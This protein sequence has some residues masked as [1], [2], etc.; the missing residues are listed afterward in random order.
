MVLDRQRSGH[1]EPVGAVAVQRH[2]DGA[3]AAVAVAR[4]FQWHTRRRIDH[5]ALARGGV[6]AGE[7]ER[8]QR[9]RTEIILRAERKKVGQGKSV[10]VRV[11]IDGRGNNK[12]KKK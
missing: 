1:V 6:P 8:T 12:K 10:S 3:E 11:D 9:N 4:E 7:G 5:R 2:V